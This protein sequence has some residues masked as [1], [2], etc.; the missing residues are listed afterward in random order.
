MCIH[1][2]LRCS[3]FTASNLDS[4]S[5][6]LVLGYCS[7]LVYLDSL[8]AQSGCMAKGARQFALVAF[9]AFV[10]FCFLGVHVFL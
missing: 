10:V 1:I 4:G 6:I 5:T 3:R 9:V 2:H 8:I 7:V